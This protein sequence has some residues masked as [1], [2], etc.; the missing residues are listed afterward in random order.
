MGLLITTIDTK[1]DFKWIF[2][3]VNLQ[4]NIRRILME[5]TQ[6]IESFLTQIMET[7]PNTER[8]IDDIETFIKNSNCKKIE[9]AKFKY[10]ALGLAVHNGVLFN[11]VIFKQELPDFLFIIF[12]EIAH[13]YQY[14]KYGDDKMYE[15]YLDETDVKDAAIEMKKIE[16]TADEFANRKVR[17]FVK[18]GFISATNG[19]T[20]SAYKDVPLSHF[21]RLITQTKDMIKLKNVSGFNEIADLFYNIMKVNTI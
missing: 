7:Y 10:P 15:F 4:E 1:K 5:E 11:E 3:Y 6:G 18:L 19:K 13:Q 21:E 14:K 12:H 9:I 2:I 17:E 20:V 16:I 8:F